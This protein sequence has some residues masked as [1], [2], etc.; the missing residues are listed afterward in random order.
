MKGNAGK[1]PGYGVV[2]GPG[3]GVG[4]PLPS[5]M[6]ALGTVG[7]IPKG[8]YGIPCW[9]TAVASAAGVLSWDVSQWVPD[10]RPLSEVLLHGVVAR[11]S[12]SGTRLLTFAAA[13]KTLQSLLIP[14]SQSIGLHCPVPLPWS[15]GGFAIPGAVDATHTAS[16]LTLL[17]SLRQ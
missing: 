16:T 10:G 17:L 4:I 15:A 14:D 3:L 12:G 2:G 6:D 13:G 9:A 7:R 11:W 1:S 8:C 5:A